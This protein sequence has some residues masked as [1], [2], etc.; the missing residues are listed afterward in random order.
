MARHKP[1]PAWDIYV[2]E[3]VRL[4]ARLGLPPELSP[5][6]AVVPMLHALL[7]RIERLEAKALPEV[8]APGDL[9]V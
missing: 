9:P 1:D 6:M 3:G 2:A 7:D 8:M 4:V 5:H